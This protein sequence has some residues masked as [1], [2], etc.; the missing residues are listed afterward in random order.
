MGYVVR[1]YTGHRSLALLALFASSPA[2]A[3]SDV[4]IWMEPTVPEPRVLSRADT[5]TGGTAHLAWTDLS[6][7]PAPSATADDEAYTALSETLD[8]ARARWTEFEVEQDIAREIDAKL[9]AIQVIR[10]D[11]DREILTEARLLQAA[12]VARA[13]EP[14]ELGTEKKAADWRLGLGDRVVVRAWLDAAALKGERRLNASDLVDGTAWAD[15]R[16]DEDALFAVTDAQIDL[17]SAPAEVKVV[18]DGREIPAGQKSVDLIPGQHWVH[19]I[20]HGK[21]AGRK[22][23][24]LEPGQTVPLPREV[25]DAELA[26]AKVRVLQ[27]TTTGLPA[28]VKAAAERLKAAYGGAVFLGALDDR[29]YEVVP[30][31]GAASLQQRKPVTFLGVGEVGGGF[32]MSSLFNEA[33]GEVL[34]VP[35]VQGGLGFELGIYNFALLGGFDIAFTP[36]HTATFGS[37]DET[38]NRDTSILPQA[39]GGLGGY[40]LRP[41]GRKPTLLAA[42]TFGWNG[43][44]HLAAGG[45]ITVG[46]PLDDRGTWWRFTFLGNHFPSAMW[47]TGG[48]KTPMTVLMLRTGLGA[49]F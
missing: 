47:D 43:P 7:P 19:V 42:G 31:L 33:N 24:R 16:R 34:S 11:H 12:A 35:S 14:D 15:F 27:G 30:Y 28:G 32:I 18:I 3:G 37:Q 21:I 8:Q 36:N 44:A 39:W 4:A 46:L 9:A 25:S 5:D 2:W 6:F 40:I 48:E 41:V 13:F 23:L 17:S 49:Q 20:H 22:V 45:R 38:S 29:K 10:S 1:V 26:D